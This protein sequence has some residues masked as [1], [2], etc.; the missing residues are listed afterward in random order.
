MGLLGMLVFDYLTI[1]DHN[2]SQGPTI[3]SA[4]GCECLLSYVA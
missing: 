1:G 4:E 3:L 2:C